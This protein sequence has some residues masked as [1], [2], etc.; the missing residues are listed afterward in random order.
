MK[1]LKGNP[2]AKVIAIILLAASC[3][4]VCGAIVAVSWL[5]GEGAYRNNSIDSVRTAFIDKQLQSTCF[6]L[7]DRMQAMPV[8]SAYDST[9]RFEL[10]DEKG[11]VLASNLSE[12][13][14]VEH[15]QIVQVAGY[16]GGIYFTAEDQPLTTW[17]SL[18][19]DYSPDDGLNVRPEVTPT[20]RPVPTVTPMSEPPVG[21]EPMPAELPVPEGTEVRSVRLYWTEASESAEADTELRLYESLYPFRYAL[22]AV[23]AV[24]L[25]LAVARSKRARWRGSRLTYCFLRASWGSPRCF[26]SSG[27]RSAAGDSS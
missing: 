4:V 25:L 1:K 10:L 20:P 9:T 6:E 14:T 18:S 8:R 26:W 22:I 21:I 5:D 17:E 16:Y 15:T 24:A 19:W 2:T 11:N 12:S 13:E 27:K 7:L 3:L 23:G